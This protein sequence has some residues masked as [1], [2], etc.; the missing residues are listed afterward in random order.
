V[1][2]GPSFEPETLRLVE[3]VGGDNLVRID[4]VPAELVA[5]AYHAAAVHVLP[6][7]SEGAALA[8]LEA[9]AAGCPLVVSDRS[10]EFEY[11]G[12]L[13]AYC[14]PADPDTIRDAIERQLDAREREPDRIAELSARMRD[15]TWEKTAR[16]TLRA[17][18]LALRD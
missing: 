2:V 11:F 16:A 8:N 15:L 18:E 14:N 6:S 1:L 13:A 7:W 9:A 3:R 10:S 17:Y 12:D 4:R 5:S